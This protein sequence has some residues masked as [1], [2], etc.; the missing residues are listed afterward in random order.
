[1]TEERSRKSY[2]ETVYHRGEEPTWEVG[3]TL[4]YYEFYS[5][6]EGESVL[7]KV[8]KIELDEDFDDWCYYFDSGS[9][10]LER[11]LITEE[12]YVKTNKKK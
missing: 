7:G 8:V 4:A 3:D 6:Y 2:I 11:D 12:A 1:M 9:F 10:E 5:D